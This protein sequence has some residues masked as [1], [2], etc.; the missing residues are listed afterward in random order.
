M[1]RL[2]WLYCVFDGNLDRNFIVSR[3]RK[4]SYGWLREHIA[5][6]KARLAGSEI[7]RGAVVAVEGDYSPEV[8]ALL[9]AL[10]DAGCI[11]VPLAAGSAPQREEFRAIAE[12][13][14]RICF[15]E[16]DSF[17]IT[18][19]DRA[20]DNPV[21]QSLIALGDPGL[22]LFSSGST[23]KSKAALHNFA[24]LL[25]KFRVRRN[26]MVTL[27]MLLLDHIGGIN[28]LF[29]ILS[30][31]GTVVAVEN[32]DPDTVCSAIAR[33]RAELLPTSPTFLNL[34]LISEAWRRHDLSSLRRIT[35]GTEV[36][37]ART[38]Q[39]LHEI[40][41]EVELLQTYGLS[42]LG[43]LRS[44]SRSS[45]SLWVRVG[46]EGVETRVQQGT[47]WIRTRSA[48]LGYLNAPSPFDEEGWFNTGDTVEVDGEYLRILGRK[49]EVIN[50]GG[51]KVYPVE[52]ENILLDMP[53]VKDVTVGAMA[54]PITGQVVMARF[55][56]FEAEGLPAFRRRM[57][58][59]CGSRLASYKVPA[60]VEIV[61]DAQYSERFKKMRKAN[62][63]ELEG[64]SCEGSK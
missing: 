36:M 46:G 53:N 48:M 3:E 60:K 23:G 38:L 24:R 27:T 7:G 14:A 11:V 2:D 43:I 64:E 17:T 32:R 31:A 44:K 18:R 42:E 55:N 40:L 45:D 49:S 39:R 54:N 59:F 30:N 6:W 4:Y 28:T 35:Y 37:P 26:S 34:L 58:E 29:Y 33:H 21:T 41:P 50:V 20:V 13:Q 8:V 9:L 22:V 61:D 10:I 1:C 47:L 57:R 25:E 12:V 5:E 62:Q 52:V 51:E 63:P 19:D 16:G 15:S 56:L